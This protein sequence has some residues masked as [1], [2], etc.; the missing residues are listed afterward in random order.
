MAGCCGGGSVTPP[1]PGD[2]VAVVTP[3][4]RYKVLYFNGTSEIVTGEDEA[5]KR[6]FDPSTR[7]E[8]T[9]RDGM[10]GATW[11]VWDE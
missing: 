10:L 1:E 5:R 6:A 4:Q 3:D 11:V 7:A 9:D 2:A 8:G